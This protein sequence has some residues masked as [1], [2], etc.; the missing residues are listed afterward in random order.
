MHRPFWQVPVPSSDSVQ[1]A[2]SARPLH[3]VASDPETQRLPFAQTLPS[4]HSRSPHATAWLFTHAPSSNTR[5]IGVRAK[6][7]TH[8][9]YQV[10][11]L[12]RFVAER[13]QRAT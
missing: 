4:G 2:P 13:G 8:R 7:T 1:V 11:G 9:M 5:T 6:P 3:A 10:V 12:A